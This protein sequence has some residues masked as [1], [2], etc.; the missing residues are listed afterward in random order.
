MTSTQIEAWAEQNYM[1]KVRITSQYDAV[2]P[3]G[4]VIE[5]EINDNTVIDKI[6]RDTPIYIVVSKGPEEEQSKDIEIPDFKT[7]GISE[8][9]IFAQE[10]GLN[11]AD[12]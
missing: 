6:K 10:N 11:S 5:Y 7:M 8:T 2:V 9:I 12:R 3:L 4:Y 1:S